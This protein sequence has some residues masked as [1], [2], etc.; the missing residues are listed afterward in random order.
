MHPFLSALLGGALVGLSASMLL[1]L[2]GRV[3]GIS[4]IFGG[5][6]APS[7]GERAWRGAFVAGLVLAG[8][9]AAALAPQAFDAGPVRSIGSTAIAGLLVG[10]GTRL[11]NGCTSGHGICGLSRFSVRSL[12]A[13]VT[14]MGTAGITVYLAN[15]VVGGAQ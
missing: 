9:A 15:H 10:F 6:L 3:A 1:L 4:G 5:L 2:N 12:V 13:V 14:F 11:G 8:V 7:E